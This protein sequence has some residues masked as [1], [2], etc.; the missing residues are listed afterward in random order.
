MAKLTLSVDATAIE[1]GKQYAQQQGRTLSSIVESYLN[2]L[3]PSTGSNA[4][5]PAVSSLMGIGSGP[6]DESDYH[7]HLV[8]KH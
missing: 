8:E 7:R 5:P 4:L 1:N 2:S 6:A 3:T